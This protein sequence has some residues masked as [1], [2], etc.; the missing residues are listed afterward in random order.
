MHIH[1][2]IHTYIHTNIHTYIYIYIYTHVYI[3]RAKYYIPEIT[4]GKFH[5]KVSQKVLWAIPVIFHW[6]RDSPWENTAEK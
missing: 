4:K 2:H 3:Y 6:T 1:T 5:R